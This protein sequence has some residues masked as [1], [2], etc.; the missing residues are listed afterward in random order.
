[1]DAKLI[2]DRNVLKWRINIIKDGRVYG[3]I[4]PNDSIV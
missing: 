1:M 4:K 2:E 3:F